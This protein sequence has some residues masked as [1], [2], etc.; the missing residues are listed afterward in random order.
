[1]NASDIKKS[2]PNLVILKYLYAYFN[3]FKSSMERLGKTEEDKREYII[4]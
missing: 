2:T 1:M 4:L 3:Y